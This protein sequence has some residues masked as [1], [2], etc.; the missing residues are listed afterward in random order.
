MSLGPAFITLV[1]TALKWPTQLRRAG[2]SLFKCT[3]RDTPPPILLIYSDEQEQYVFPLHELSPGKSKIC[4]SF[5]MV[6]SF[7]CTECIYTKFP[8]LYRATLAF[9]RFYLDNYREKH[10]S[11][12]GMHLNGKKCRTIMLMKYTSYLK[13]LHWCQCDTVLGLTREKDMKSRDNLYWGS[14]GRCVRN[15]VKKPVFNLY[16]QNSY[17]QDKL[18]TLIVT[19]FFWSLEDLRRD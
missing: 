4:S 12:S 17:L 13:Q 10:F 6:G 18:L 2:R 7:L 15:E 8:C 16:D 19:I 9:S 14:I 11:K 3:Q 1:L 5:S